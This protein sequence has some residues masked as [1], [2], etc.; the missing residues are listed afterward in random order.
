LDNSSYKD[1]ES[2][3]KNRDILND[4]ISKII[5]KNKA[6]YWIEKLNKVGV[7]CGPV[8]NIAQ[9]FDDPQVQHLDMT[10]KVKHKRLGDLS[11]VGQP[12]NLSN[13]DQPKTF[14]YPAPEL[15]EHLEEVLKEFGYNSDEIDK[16]KI[17]NAIA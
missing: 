8:N 11:V 3:L 16:L 9:V 17:N 7:P 2:R 10:H 1:D 4:E 14:R 15:G 6:D 13:A 12:I 5:I